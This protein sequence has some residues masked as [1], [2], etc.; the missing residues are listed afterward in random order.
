MAL[1]LALL[2]SASYNI[3]QQLRFNRMYWFWGSTF[4]DRLINGHNRIDRFLAETEADRRS[5][6]LFAIQE[7]PKEI[8]TLGSNLGLMQSRVWP[9][10]ETYLGTVGFELNMFTIGVWNRSR[11]NAAVLGATTNASPATEDMVRLAQVYRIYAKHFP[12]EVVLSQRPAKHKKAL[13][14]A[15]EELRQ[16][17]L[18]ELLPQQFQ[19]P[20]FDQSLK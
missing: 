5:A 8:Q 14:A 12:E 2:V 7:A 20:A 9:F 11:T 3:Y 6:G 16:Q 13:Q 18:I 19:G 10:P 15:H 1:A 17:G 4:T